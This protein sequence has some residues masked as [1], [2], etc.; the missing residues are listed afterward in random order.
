[1]GEDVDFFAVNGVANPRLVKAFRAFE[2]PLRDPEAL[3]RILD[4]RCGHFLSFRQDF[5]VGSYPDMRRRVRD[6]LKKIRKLTAELLGEGKDENDIYGFSLALEDIFPDHV[7]FKQREL[8]RQRLIAAVLF[9]SDLPLRENLSALQ[10][11]PNLDENT[12]EAVRAV[13]EY[14]T[15][16]EGREFT[17]SAGRE[18]GRAGFTA[19]TGSIAELTPRVLKALGLSYTDSEVETHLR[20]VQDALSG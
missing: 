12:A 6:K 10:G 13:H 4:R 16:V 14:W 3:A 1:M 18:G 8:L 19:N 17:S 11:R 20:K 15:T 7:T 5:E 9:F 2:P